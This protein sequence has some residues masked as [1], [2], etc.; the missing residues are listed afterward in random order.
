M[1]TEGDLLLLLVRRRGMC[2]VLR[3]E[4]AKQN[5]LGGRGKVVNKDD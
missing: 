1:W 4:V 2:V 5:K 3:N